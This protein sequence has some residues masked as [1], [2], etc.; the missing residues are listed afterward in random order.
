MKYFTCPHLETLETIKVLK[1]GSSHLV[2][3]DT[4]GENFNLPQS[5][6]DLLERSELNEAQ[7]NC[8]DPRASGLLQWS[9]FAV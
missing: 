1:A 2:E 6:V 4:N 8:V 3:I 5:H 9:P 7:F